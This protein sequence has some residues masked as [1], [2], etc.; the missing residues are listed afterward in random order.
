MCFGWLRLLCVRPALCVPGWAVARQHR[1]C[2]LCASHVSAALS[3]MYRSQIILSRP[4]FPR[5]SLPRCR[6]SMRSS[7]VMFCSN[8]SSDGLCSQCYKAKMSDMT[9]KLDQKVPAAPNVDSRPARAAAASLPQA[10]QEPDAAGPPPV[11]DAGPPVAAGS[12]QPKKKKR[13]S[14][15]KKKVGI[16]G[17]ECKCGKLLCTSHRT[18]EDHACDFDYR[19][20]GKKR[21]ADANPLVAF[22]KVDSI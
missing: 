17:W 13:C 8:E 14:V 22:S 18:P 5:V 16:L 2:A 11:S 4:V 20:E 1:F 6:V 21:L 3:I 15:C 12:E 19:T 10:G 7:L 9:L